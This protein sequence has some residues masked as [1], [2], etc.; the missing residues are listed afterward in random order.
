MLKKNYRFL[1]FE[2]DKVQLLEIYKTYN[3]KHFKICLL[4]E[5]FDEIFFIFKKGYFIK[6][7]KLNKIIKFKKYSYINANKFKYI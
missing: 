4:L 2:E 5:G 1:N 3:K 6:K 7:Y